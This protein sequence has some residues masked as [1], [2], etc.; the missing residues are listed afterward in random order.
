MNANPASSPVLSLGW[1]TLP[2]ATPLQLVD[3]AAAAGFNG[4]GLRVAPR[5]HETDPAIVGDPS[6]ARALGRSLRDNQ[7]AAFQMGSLWLDGRVPVSGYAPALETGARLGARMAIAIATA[8][9]EPGRLKEDFARLC[10]LAAGYGIRMAVEFFAF[11]GI[12]TFEE[13][14][15]LVVESGRSNAGIL[16]DALHFHRSGGQVPALK[17]VADTAPHRLFFTQLCDAPAQAPEYDGLSREARRDRHDPGEGAL[18]L[19]RFYQTLPAGLPI[20]V[21]APCLAYS[22]LSAIERANIAG[23][24]LR[25]FLAR[26]DETARQGEADAAV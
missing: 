1:L 23:T 18:P 9:I 19:A 13:A 2:R 21:E 3:A 26:M 22:S 11:S 6:L 5:P 12:R 15:R 24:A 14:D 17:A 7:I 16:V 4:V 10:E 20:E 25:K 8:D